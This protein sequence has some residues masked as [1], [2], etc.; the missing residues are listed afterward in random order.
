M[1]QV[2]TVYNSDGVT[3]LSILLTKRGKLI[4]LFQMYIHNTNNLLVEALKSNQP[5]STRYILTSPS[6]RE[7]KDSL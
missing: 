1:T 4:F 2:F 3:T 5:L 6:K 7:Q